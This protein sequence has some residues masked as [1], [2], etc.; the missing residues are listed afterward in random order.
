MTGSL[1]SFNSLEARLFRIFCQPLTGTATPSALPQ[2]PRRV[3]CCMHE[4]LM[5]PHSVSLFGIVCS[6][7]SGVRGWTPLDTPLIPGPAR[8]IRKRSL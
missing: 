4:T 2:T 8:K 3:V 7:N 6:F 5:R 1:A